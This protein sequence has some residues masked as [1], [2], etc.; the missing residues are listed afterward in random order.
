MARRLDVSASWLNPTMALDPPIIIATFGSPV[1]YGYRMDVACHRCQRNVTIDAATAF[2]PELSYIARRFRCSC[3]ERC[4]PKGVRNGIYPTGHYT[5]DA[6][7][8]RRQ[9]R[10]LMQEGAVRVA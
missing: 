4:G 8:E 3:G 5:A 2:P 6:R 7:D 9:R 10:A 1:R